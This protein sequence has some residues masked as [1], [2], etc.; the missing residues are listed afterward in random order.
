[1]APEL[2]WC[3]VGLVEEVGVVG[4][5][6]EEGVA[7]VLLEAAGLSVFMTDSNAGWSNWE[8]YLGLCFKRISDVA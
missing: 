2:A 6:G 7:A 5:A 3:F 4:V 8:G 1:M